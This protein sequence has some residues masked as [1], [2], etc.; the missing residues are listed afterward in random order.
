M[1]P[2]N[3]SAINMTNNAVRYE[4]LKKEVKMLC[5]IGAGFGFVV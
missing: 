2:M 4:I 1:I 5:E 3:I